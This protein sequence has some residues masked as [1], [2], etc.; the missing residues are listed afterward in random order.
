MEKKQPSSRM[1]LAY[2]HSNFIV[3]FRTWDERGSHVG[4]NGI[5]DKFIEDFHSWK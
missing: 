1:L 5:T 4:L 2:C 3:N